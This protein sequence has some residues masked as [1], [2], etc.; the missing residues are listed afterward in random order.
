MSAP[1]KEGASFTAL[2]QALTDHV[3]PHDTATRA[4]M[5][6]AVA[7]NVLWLLYEEAGLEEGQRL[8]SRASEMSLQRG[9]AVS[10][11]KAK[12]V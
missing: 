2:M 8:F 10:L 11:R 7:A 12:H 4:L 1:E 5:L 3:S 6:A 9:P